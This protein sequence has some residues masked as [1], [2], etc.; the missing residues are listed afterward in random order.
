MSNSLL[1]NWTQLN[2]VRDNFIEC[3]NYTNFAA[4]N[5]LI[6]PAAN[7]PY[8]N[9]NLCSEFAP[10]NREYSGITHISNTIS[11]LTS[12]N[13]HSN[14]KI[15]NANFPH[16]LFALNHSTDRLDKNFSKFRRIANNFHK[17]FDDVAL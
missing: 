3:R 13:S 12:N 15:E 1:L 8:C 7:I 14:A 2:A 10:R 5:P 9:D 6:K 11:E 17:R 4:Q 16:S